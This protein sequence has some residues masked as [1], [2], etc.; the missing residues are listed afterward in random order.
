MGGTS[1]TM[2][3]TSTTMGGTSTTYPMDQLVSGLM[4]QFSY[5]TPDQI[6]E[7]LNSGM[8]LLSLVGNQFG[9][10]T[11]HQSNQLLTSQGM[12]M[13]STYKTPSTNIIQTDFSGTSN[14]FSPYLYYNKGSN[15]TFTN[16][17]NK[18]DIYN[19]DKYNR[20]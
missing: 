4:S 9:Q 20:Y 12:N 1:T 16:I 17:K 14:V 7:L 13:S 19:V 15:E 18:N 10:N 3:G 2:G 5:L 6:A 11:D 8:D